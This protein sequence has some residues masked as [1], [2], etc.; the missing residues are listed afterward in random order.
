MFDNDTINAIDWSRRHTI[1]LTREP[2][3][4]AQVFKL[5]VDGELL[6]TATTDQAGTAATVAAKTV[7][8]ASKGERHVYAIRFYSKAI[9]AAEAL[10]NHNYAI[11][12]FGK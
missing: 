11:K 2:S 10:Q 7:Y 3:T 6:A 8:L 4:T 1:Q 9:S 12:R 5:Y